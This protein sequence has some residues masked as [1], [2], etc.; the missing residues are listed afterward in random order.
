MMPTVR[1]PIAIATSRDHVRNA[2]AAFPPVTI[3]TSVDA[4][5]KV[6]VPGYPGW[7]A[8]RSAAVR[9]ARRSSR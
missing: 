6:L 9:R 4:I 5:A 3:A 7:D 8:F 2:D 1:E